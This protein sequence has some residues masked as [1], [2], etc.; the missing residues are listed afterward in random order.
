MIYNIMHGK[1]ENMMKII[2]WGDNYVVFDATFNFN[3]RR[4]INHRSNSGEI[5]YEFYSHCQ[6]N[7]SSTCYDVKRSPSQFEKNI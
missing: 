7:L 5:F 6:H 1:V 4:F 3:I 2:W